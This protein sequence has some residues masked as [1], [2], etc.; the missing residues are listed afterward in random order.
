VSNYNVSVREWEEKIVFLHKIVRG[1]ADKSYGIHVSRLAGVPDWVNR[2][3]E[4]ILERLETKNDVEENREA[5]KSTGRRSQSGIQ[6]TLFEAEHPLIDRI[7][8]LEPNH[9]TPIAALEMLQQFKE[10]V[11]EGS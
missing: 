2:R 9:L 1:S 4:K 11:G 6:L 3:A 8:T 7:R 5:I 10:E